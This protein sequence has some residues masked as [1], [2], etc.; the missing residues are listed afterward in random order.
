MHTITTIIRQEHFIVGDVKF[1]LE[2]TD[3]KPTKLEM[4]T[5]CVSYSFYGTDTIQGLSEFFKEL[6][7]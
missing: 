5:P 4:H 3:D 6:S 2:L 7:V 1:M